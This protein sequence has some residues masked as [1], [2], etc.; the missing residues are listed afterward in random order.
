[1]LPR[2][3]AAVRLPVVFTWA[4]LGAA[5]AILLS[6]GEVEYRVKGAMRVESG[7]GT[8]TLPYDQRGRF[9]APAPR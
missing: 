1:V 2:D 9:G 8:I 5:N 3:S 7:V 4:G 6:R